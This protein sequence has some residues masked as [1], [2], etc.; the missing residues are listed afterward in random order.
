MTVSPEAEAYKTAAAWIAQQQ[1][2]KPF[3]GPVML[4]IKLVPKNGRVMDLDNC[5]KVSID[6]LKGIAYEDDKQVRKIVAEYGE[7]DGKGAL[8]VEIKELE[9]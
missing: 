6:A 4:D 7:A 2:C 8:I 5:L 1:G 9:T 3:A